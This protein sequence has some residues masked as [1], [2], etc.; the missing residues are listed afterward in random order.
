M[1]YKN[2]LGILFLSIVLFLTVSI[3][4]AQASYLLDPQTA[5]EEGYW[6]SRYNLG[7]LVMRSGLGVQFMPE[8]KMV[9][10]AIKMVDEDFNPMQKGKNYGDKD[11]AIPPVKP[12]LLKAVYKSGSP[13]YITKFNAADFSTQRWDPATFDKTLTGAANGYTILKEVEWAKQ[14]HVDEHFGTPKSDFGAYWRFAGMVLNMEAKMQAMYFHENMDKYDLSGVGAYVMLWGLSDLGNT[15]EQDKLPNSNSN[16]YKDLK[17]SSFV[18]N[19]VDTLFN[20]IK[21]AKLDSIKDK[22]TTIQALVW[23]AM[24]T[25]NSVN[26]KA[27]LSKIDQLAG[28]LKLLNS[29]TI[30]DKAYA[31]QG[32]IEAKRVLGGE[33]SNLYT[34]TEGFLSDFDDSVGFFKSQTTYSIDDVAV[35]VGA[36]NELRIFENDKVNAKRVNEV[37]ARFFETVVDKAGLQLSAPPLPIAKSKF[38]YEG[39]PELFFR[40]P[41]MPFP[42]MAG[43]K[44]GIAPVFGT[45]VTYKDGKWEVNKIFD[46]AGA[47]HASNEMIWLHHDEIN[48]FPDVK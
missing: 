8:M 42:P 34:L 22:S 47:M 48:G 23:Y 21:G 40:Y 4:V 38:E 3:S 16:R 2:L 14:F 27:A 26:K 9:V 19:A 46:T 6:Y 15:L 30:S 39:E 43:G 37:F 7:N 44:Y 25:H 1:K 32:L 10:G 13:Y 29:V 12:A 45:S 17:A 36:L 41:S 33:I 24:A 31:I 5:E 11:H 35:I 28:E 20:K 18:L